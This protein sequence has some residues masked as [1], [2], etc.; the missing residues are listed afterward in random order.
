M[1]ILIRLLC[2]LMLLLQVSC[3]SRPGLP[4]VVI[5]LADDLGYGDVSFCNP[6]ARTDT[7]CIDELGRLG[8]SFTDAH[9]AGAVC[10]PSRYGLL[11][12]RYFFRLPPKPIHWGYGAPLIEKGRETIGSLMQKAGYTTACV[13]KWHLGLDWG[14]RDPGLPQFPEEGYGGFTNTDFNRGIARGPNA[15]GFDY[16]FILPASLDMPP[17]VFIRNGEVMDPQ[18][19]LVSDIYPEPEGATNL[20]WD[21]KYTRPGDVYR[22]RVAIRSDVCT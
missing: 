19:V 7:P 3:R 21:R 11:T 13:G 8:M 6:G 22:G 17:Y 12:G 4:N 15:L 9:S 2:I 20:T 1:R 10:I 14:L 18:V 5:I 16:S